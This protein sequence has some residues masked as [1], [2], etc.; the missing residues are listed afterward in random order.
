M[1][2]FQP[3]HFAVMSSDRELIYSTGGRGQNYWFVPSFKKTL[4]ELVERYFV[5]LTNEQIWWVRLPNGT[6][7][8]TSEARLSTLT[9][10]LLPGLEVTFEQSWDDAKWPKEWADHKPKAQLQQ[11][12]ITYVQNTGTIYIAYS[13]PRNPKY[14]RSPPVVNGRFHVKDLKQILAITLD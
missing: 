5:T 8:T 14:S 10:Y 11:G 4:V 3:G 12:R 6:R 1:S 7:M 9:S 13:A 2:E